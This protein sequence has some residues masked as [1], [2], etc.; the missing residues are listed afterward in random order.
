MKV[1]LNFKLD[2]YELLRDAINIGIR[3]GYYRA[4]KH[5]DA[6]TEDAL[7]ESILTCVMGEIAEIAE[8][9]TETEED[10]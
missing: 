3:R 1:T 2:P 8:I 6:P 7:C 10:E 4:H 5:V 9:E